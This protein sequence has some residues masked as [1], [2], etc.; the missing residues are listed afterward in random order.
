MTRDPDEFQTPEMA[1]AAGGY[2]VRHLALHQR[3]V[4]EPSHLLGGDARRLRGPGSLV[5]GLQQ[6]EESRLI[7]RRR[8]KDPRVLLQG[9][10]NDSGLQEP[11]FGRTEIDRE[12]LIFHPCILLHLPLTRDRRQ[13]LDALT[14]LG[15]D[16]SAD[17]PGW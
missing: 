3:G 10:V 17:R 15:E 13:L 7:Q 4:Q 6:G 11:S 9:S 5:A 2:H 14:R 8:K 12:I 16:S 1:F